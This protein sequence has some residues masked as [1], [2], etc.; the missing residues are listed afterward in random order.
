V[1]GG[2][3]GRRRLAGHRDGAVPVR[4]RAGQSQA[5]LGDGP[6]EDCG[7]VPAWHDARDA[8]PGL[9]ADRSVRAGCGGRPSHPRRSEAATG[10]TARGRGL[11][12]AFCRRR[13][14]ARGVGATVPVARFPWPCEV[15][16]VVV[17]GVRCCRGRCSLLSWD[18][19]EAAARCQPRIKLALLPRIARLLKAS[20]STSKR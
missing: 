8:Q 7:G 12:A 11:R 1:L 16:A 9:A 15:F 14:R 6:P 10:V 5:H 18:E 19:Q 3:Q 2:V 20:S 4:S 13:S 17:G